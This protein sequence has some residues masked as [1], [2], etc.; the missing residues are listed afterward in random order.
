MLAR[1]RTLRLATLGLVACLSS[2]CLVISLQ[3]VYDDASLIMDETLTGTWQSA[4]QGATVVVERG[5][6]KAYRVSY[7]ARTTSYALVGYLTRIGDLSVFDLTPEHGVEAGPLLIP[8]HGICRIQRDGDT[9]SISPLD[10]DWFTAAR[11]GKKLAGLDY[12]L[13]GRQNL[14]ITTKTEALRAWLLAHAKSAEMFR[15]PT[16]FTR[17]K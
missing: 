7:T 4:E 6:W 1:A 15:E 9:L 10:Y 16:T 14:L 12:A 13:D 5:E 17:V 11:G 3:P 2:G 8:A